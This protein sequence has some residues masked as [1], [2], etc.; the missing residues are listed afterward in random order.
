MGDPGAFVPVPRLLDDCASGLD[1]PDLSGDFAVRIDTG[2]VIYP[3]CSLDQYFAGEEQISQ[4]AAILAASLEKEPSEFTFDFTSQPIPINARD[5]RIQVVYTGP[6]G[7]EADGIAFGGRDISE[8]THL[9]IY[10]NSDYYA[11]DGVFHTPA[12]IR[13]DPA[14]VA[15]YLGEESDE[16]AGEGAQPPRPALEETSA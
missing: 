16:P 5:L 13:A 11:V 4:S 10:N 12:E 1:Q 14:V 2:E 9:M 3:P 7:A 6:L 15:A 8:P